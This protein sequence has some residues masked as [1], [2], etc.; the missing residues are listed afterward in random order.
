MSSW[1][2]C[3]LDEVKDLSSLLVLAKLD[4]SV[5]LERLL[6]S[7]SQLT[8]GLALCLEFHWGLRIA[9]LDDGIT[10]PQCFHGI[11]QIGNI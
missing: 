9:C 6:S 2:S 5:K 8:A 3:P 1:I 11:V 10:N 7:L 4:S